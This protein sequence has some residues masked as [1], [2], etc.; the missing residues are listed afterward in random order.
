M[1]QTEFGGGATGTLTSMAVTRIV[2]AEDDASIRELLV[3]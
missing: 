1:A 3:L 2:V